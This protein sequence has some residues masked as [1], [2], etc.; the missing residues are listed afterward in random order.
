MRVEGPHVAVVSDSNRVELRLVTLGRDLGGRIVVS[1]GINGDER[2]V[3]NPT[4][5]L[6]NG[7]SVRVNEA[8]VAQR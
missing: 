7:A 6:Q 4:D 3:V 5:D 1:A 8:K 2:L